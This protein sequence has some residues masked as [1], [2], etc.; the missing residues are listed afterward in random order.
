M[1]RSKIK[2][3]DAS[4]FVWLSPAQTYAN[5]NWGSVISFLQESRTF[6]SAFVCNASGIISMS[7]SGTLATARNLNKT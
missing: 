2:A 1:Q 7:G 4:G 3:T 6:Q 5:Q